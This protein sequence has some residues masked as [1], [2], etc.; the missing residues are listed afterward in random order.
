MWLIATLSATAS[1]RHAC[2]P[3]VAGMQEHARLQ[4]HATTDHNPQEEEE[5]EA[6]ESNKVSNKLEL[7]SLDVMK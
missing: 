6:T 2:Q 1:A 3:T 7:L 5:A 4:W